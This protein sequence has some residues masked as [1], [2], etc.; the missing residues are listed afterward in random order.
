VWICFGLRSSEESIAYRNS[1]KMIYY[2]VGEP[3]GISV[4]RYVRGRKWFLNQ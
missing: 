1:L 2:L 3:C 4:V